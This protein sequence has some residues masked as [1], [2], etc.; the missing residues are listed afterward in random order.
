[1]TNVLFL[2]HICFFL[3]SQRDREDRERASQYLPYTQT[4]LSKH[5]IRE[6]FVEFVIAPLYKIYGSTATG[7]ASMFIAR[8][9]EYNILNL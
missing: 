6:A 2:L 8:K 5:S 9:T 1:M 3:E 7:K 4:G